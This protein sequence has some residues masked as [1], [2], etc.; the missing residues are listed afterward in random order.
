MQNLHQNVFK[1]DSYIIEI[2][3]QMFFVKLKDSMI[4]ETNYVYVCVQRHFINSKEEY[5]KAFGNIVICNDEA[6][7][8]IRPNLT[9][10]ERLELFDELT[11]TNVEEY[12][13]LERYYLSLL[14]IN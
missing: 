2:L 4:N 11:S 6:L 10:S 7:N 8:F 1:K 5:K 12:V 3:R 14:K 13:K 9:S